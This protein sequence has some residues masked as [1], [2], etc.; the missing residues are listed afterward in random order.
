[1]KGA[2]SFNLPG[3]VVKGHG[4]EERF[5]LEDVAQ[6]EAKYGTLVGNL[7]TNQIDASIDY[8]RMGGCPVLLRSSVVR[9]VFFKLFVTG[10]VAALVSASAESKNVWFP[11]ALSAAVN[12]VAS[13][14]Y[15]LIWRIRA[16]NM[17]ESHLHWSS[18]RLPDGSF[19]GNT[20]SVDTHESSKM[21]VQELAVDG[22]RCAQPRNAHLPP[23][24]HR[25]VTSPLARLV[26]C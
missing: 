9:V 10:V 13:I 12:L 16:Q 21:F 8:T 4:P 1:M 6:A 7:P 14:H 15:M 17:P 11:C 24:R 18:G 5:L 20:R 26:T 2:I 23:R 22:L 19:V 25:A 3:L